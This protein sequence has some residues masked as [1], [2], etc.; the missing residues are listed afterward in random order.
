MV[1][2]GSLNYLQPMIGFPDVVVVGADA[3]TKGEP[4]I[5]AAGFFGRDWG[6]PSGDFTFQGVAR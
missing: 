4:G 5:R 3:L 2:S 6:V 1:V